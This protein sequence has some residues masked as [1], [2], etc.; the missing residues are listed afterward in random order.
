[1]KLQLIRA[2][3]E[4]WLLLCLSGFFC[5]EIFRLKLRFALY[6]SCRLWLRLFQIAFVSI[7]VLPILAQ[8][9]PVFEMIPRYR[10]LTL[11]SGEQAEVFVLDAM[12]NA[13][14]EAARSVP[15]SIQNSYS[16][17][18]F[19]LYSAI[20]VGFLLRLGSQLR[21]L[22]KFSKDS[23]LFRKVGRV[24]ILA[25]PSTSSPFSFY[26]GWNCHVLFPSNYLS[27]PSLFRDALLHEL[28]HHRQRDTH[29]TFFTEL[30]CSIFLWNPGLRRWMK[31]IEELQELSCDEALIRERGLSPERYCASLLHA[32]SIARG[33][34]HPA[35]AAGFSDSLTGS[36]LTR[37]FIE[38][39]K[40]GKKS[41]RRSKLLVVGASLALVSAS[42]TAAIASQGFLH[43][44]S[45]TREEIESAAA[46]AQTESEI[47]I[48]VNDMVV[49]R[50]ARY[51][52][53]AKRR[54]FLRESFAR[55][56]QYEHMI[57][58]ELKKAQLPIDLI[59]VPLVESGYQNKTWEPGAGLWGFIRQTAR[60][61]GLIVTEG[62]DERLDPEKETGA[63]VRYFSKL[64]RQFANWHLALKSYNEGE[65]RV[66]K[67]I[68][69]HSTRD[70]WALEKLSSA[71]NYLPDVVAM[72]II[73]RNRHW[74]ED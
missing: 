27:N 5:A 15:I 40:I 35:Y 10:S 2:F 4:T 26:L 33:E 17:L 7:L 38:M 64:Y 25:S 3:A 13:P 51:L 49:S 54:T 8:F 48:V 6:G 30:F 32:A 39:L 20:L 22:Q 56:E 55:M 50:L 66:D 61:Y 67:L 73:A 65:S 58:A 23:A 59:Y 21:V 37:R 62:K 11:F 16:L 63:A 41:Q 47:P 34:T 9:L 46:K 43:D 19:L 31:C 70:A 14:T 18:T 71:D 42:A 44:R 36:F 52:G 28:Q 57:R 60:H 45:F 12:Q 1:M 29:W 69:Q 72:L 24:S 74:L 53:T 68:Q